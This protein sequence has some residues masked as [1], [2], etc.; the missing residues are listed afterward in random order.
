[1]PFVIATAAGVLSFLINYPLHLAI[2]PALR[3][4]FMQRYIRP[5]GFYVTLPEKSEIKNRLCAANLGDLVAKTNIDAQLANKKIYYR[6]VE[7]RVADNL[8]WYNAGQGIHPWES[9][10]TAAYDKQQVAEILLKDHPALVEKIRAEKELESMKVVRVKN[11][12]W[13]AFRAGENPIEPL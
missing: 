10:R 6:D 9:R 7:A 1:M 13:A 11:I 12:S 3:N 8:L 4:D 5:T 2:D